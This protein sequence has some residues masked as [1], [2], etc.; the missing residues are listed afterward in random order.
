M[1]KDICT[2]AHLYLVLSIVAIIIGIFNQFSA[3]AILVKIFF[4]LLWTTLLNYLCSK[5]LSV[6]SWIFV[7]LPF[8]AIL[9]SLILLMEG[10]KVQH[11]VYSNSK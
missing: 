6:V 11:I 9:S 7:I 3:L 8:V 2:P 4:V 5:G 10:H 1:F